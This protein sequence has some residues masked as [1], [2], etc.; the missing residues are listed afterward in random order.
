MAITTRDQL[1]SAIAAATPTPYYKASITSVAG[2]FYTT[3]RAAAGMPA[4]SGVATPTTTGNTLDRTS[5]GAFPLASAGG[6]TLY[7]A[8]ATAVGGTVGSL[9][10]ADRLVEY[11]G[12]SGT[13]TTAQ[14]VSAVS[15]PSRAGSGDGCELWMEIYSALGATPSPTVTASYTNQAGTSGRTA[16]LVGGITASLPANRAYKFALQAGDTGVQSVQSF[17]S[18]TS[19]TTA[20]NIGLTI[21]KPIAWL[22]MTP[23]NI[24]QVFGYAELG[25]PIIPTDACLEF[26]VLATTTST[27]AFYGQLTVAQG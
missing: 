5:S 25:L 14:A 8:Q 3:F 23:A 16:T 10:V 7:L 11:A 1:A 20:G 6:N 27:G 26:L 19:T 9:L 22:P 12:L 4:A 17:T 13:T 15:L 21:R 18:T 24:T 2:F